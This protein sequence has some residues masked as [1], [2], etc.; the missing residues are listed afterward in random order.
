MVYH[1]VT[2]DYPWITIN[3]VNDHMIYVE[4]S[5]T[6]FWALLYPQY[7]GVNVFIY[8]TATCRLLACF[9]VDVPNMLGSHLQR[10]L[11][12]RQLLHINKHLY[13]Q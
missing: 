9:T 10:D 4:G 1:G 3:G 6:S 7:Y 5:S 2:S 12:S 11:L 8:D 13:M